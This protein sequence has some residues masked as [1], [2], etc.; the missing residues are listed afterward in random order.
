MNMIILLC[1]PLIP[2][3]IVTICAVRDNRKENKKVT[4]T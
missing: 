1:I 3:I 4:V 2:A